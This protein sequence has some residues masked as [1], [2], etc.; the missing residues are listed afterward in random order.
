M[1]GKTS[2]FA[3][4]YEHYYSKDPA[5]GGEGFDHAKWLET[6]DDQYIPARTG[7]S[8]VKFTL[9]R[10]SS[11]EW[12]FVQDVASKEGNGSG[13][14][15]AVALALRGI[16]PYVDDKGKE[17]EIGLVRENKMQRLHDEDMDRVAT[18]DDGYL[19][20]ELAQRV[21]KESRHDPL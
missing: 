16:D 5:L 18:V 20:H 13:S 3:G 8:P 12:I 17:V 9:R 7:T 1:F 11:R 10:L 4:E 21:A 15:M 2:A 19:I 14:W 6:G